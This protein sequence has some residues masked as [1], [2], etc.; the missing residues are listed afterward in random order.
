MAKYS[1]LKHS[2][3][4]GKT[5]IANFRTLTSTLTPFRS[6]VSALA[7]GIKLESRS[8]FYK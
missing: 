3:T 4:L 8:T 7:I 5:Q 6:L 1:T 2:K